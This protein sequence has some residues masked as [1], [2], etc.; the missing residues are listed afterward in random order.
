MIP[1]CLTEGNRPILTMPFCR[2]LL[3]KTN[4]R[5]P[6]NY[7]QALVESVHNYKQ[8]AQITLNINKGMGLKRHSREVK[9][10][11]EENLVGS[12]EKNSRKKEKHKAKVNMSIEG[13]RLK[14]Q[15]MSSAIRCVTHPRQSGCQ[16]SHGRPL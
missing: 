10:E 16:C 8:S 3:S 13:I 12:T 5:S 1:L 9:V 6:E 7:T 4:P 15:D 2:F 14:G 11:R